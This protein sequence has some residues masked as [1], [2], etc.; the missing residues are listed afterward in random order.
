MVLSDLL[1]DVLGR[2]EEANPP[3]FW[4][5]L[6]E[7]YPQIVDG[8]FEAALLTGVVQAS[9]QAFTITA[10]TT[11]FILPKGMFACLRMKAPYSIRKV[12]LKGLDDMT[13][14]WQNEP[15]ATQIRVWFPL[16]VTGFGVYPQLTA[17]AVVTLDFL[18]SPVN[19][20]RPYLGNVVIPFQEEFADAFSEYGAA[21]LRAK[22]GGAEAEEAAVVYSEYMANM[23]VLSAFQGR[24]D[25]L[26]MSAA[27]GGKVQ[28]N[29]RK[30]V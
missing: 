11:Y 20:P 21:M 6:G 29:P 27:F 24:L 2:I 22:E 25:S 17:D 23:R 30:V 18:T 15:A 5:L 1:T 26:V 19:Q 13:P 28:V 12:S 4:D 7:V 16:G 8:M 14:G 10:D 9:A 3:V